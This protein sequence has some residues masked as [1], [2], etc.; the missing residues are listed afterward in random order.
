[1]LESD[2]PKCFA[3]P[4]GKPESPVVLENKEQHGW[5]PDMWITG[6]EMR[7]SRCFGTCRLWSNGSRLSLEGF[8]G[9]EVK[10]KSFGELLA[11]SHVNPK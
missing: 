7:Q 2:L 6:K 1:M 8:K 9:L 5:R 10:G 3:F 4:G 11:E